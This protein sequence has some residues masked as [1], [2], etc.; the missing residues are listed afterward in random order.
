MGKA[1]G[2]A[3]IVTGLA[4]LAYG[5]LP[6]VTPEPVVVIGPEYVERDHSPSLPVAPIAGA[7]AM[8]TG[9]VLVFLSKR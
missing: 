6:L 8:W 4:G 3:M 9:S 7:L 1:L 5:A 2:I